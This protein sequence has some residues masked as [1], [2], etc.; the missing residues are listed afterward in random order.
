MIFLYR[1]IHSN[2]LQFVLYKVAGLGLNL[3]KKESL[4]QVFPCESCE[5]S[6]NTFFYRTP[7]DDCFCRLSSLCKEFGKFA[8]PRPS[9]QLH[10][11]I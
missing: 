6:K 10:V 2:T 4:A 5:I 3:I 9:R 11:Q 8:I 1:H 7:P